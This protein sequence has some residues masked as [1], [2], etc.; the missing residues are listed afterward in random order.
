MVSHKNTKKSFKSKSIVP[1][2]KDEWIEVQNTHILLV[3]EETFE[4]AQ[5]IIR[6]KSAPL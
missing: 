4:H 5:K 1:V 6:V 2:L 3:D